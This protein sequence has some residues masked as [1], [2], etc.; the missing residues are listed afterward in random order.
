MAMYRVQ[1]QRGLSMVKFM[2]RYGSDRRPRMMNVLTHGFSGF[3]RR[4]VP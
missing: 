2:Q 3:L 4:A 1:F